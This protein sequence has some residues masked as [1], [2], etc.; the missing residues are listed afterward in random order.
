MVD[1]A[2]LIDHLLHFPQQVAGDQH[3]R[4]APVGHVLDETAHLL[5]AGGVEAVGGFIQNQQLWV[6]KQRLGD[7]KTLAHPQ[8]ILLHLPATAVGQLYDLQ[9][10]VN[11]PLRDVFQLCQNL[12]IFLPGQMAV[13]GGGLDEG[14]SLPQQGQPV[15]RG[16]G[17]SQKADA[18]AVGL[19]QPQQHLHGGGFSRAVGADEAVD[20]AFRD[21]QGKT[22]HHGHFPIIFGEMFGFD[23]LHSLAPFLIDG[24]SLHPQAYDCLALGLNLP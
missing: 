16:H 10:P 2:H 4:A 23:D 21:G 11:I 6:S 17:L 7:S 14:A 5:D 13:A 24:A 12:Q 22:V 15:L 18:P 9:N 19:H 20:A 8:R 1:D 3:R